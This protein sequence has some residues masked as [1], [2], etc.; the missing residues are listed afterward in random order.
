MVA[1]TELKQKT[2]LLNLTEHKVSA[3]EAMARKVANVA[4][5]ILAFAVLVVGLTAGGVVAGLGAGDVVGAVF[6]G[7]IG[8]GIGMGLFMAAKKGINHLTATPEEREQMREK[9]DRLD[10]ITPIQKQAEITARDML[11]DNS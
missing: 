8:F 6:G 3:A 4:L 5:K 11:L 10:A 7:I 2:P 9:Q 1:V